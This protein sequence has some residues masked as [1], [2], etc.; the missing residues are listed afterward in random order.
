M[1]ILPDH[2]PVAVILDIKTKP[3]VLCAPLPSPGVV[4]PEA[5]PLVVTEPAPIWI[6]KLDVP[7][8]LTP[9][10]ITVTRFT[11]A[12]M[13]VKSMLVPLVDATAVPI[14]IPVDVGADDTHAVPLLVSTFPEVLGAVLMTVPVVLGSVS[15]VSVAAAAAER[16][17]EPPPVP[18]IDTGT[19]RHSNSCRETQSPQFRLLPSPGRTYRH[20]CP[21]G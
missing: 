5:Y 8:V 19:R 3:A 12:G 15:V 1:T 9:L 20:S 16:V 10:N 6:W 4:A 21:W 7:L 11:V 13:L 17:T 14:V 2:N 18:L